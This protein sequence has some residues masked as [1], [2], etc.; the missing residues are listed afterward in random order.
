[1]GRQTRIVKLAYSVDE[2]AKALGL[3][4][5]SV[6]LLVET[7]ELAKV[8]TRLARVLISHDELERWSNGR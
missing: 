1:M 4:P 7:G 3:S 5:A 2:A 8:K 6:R